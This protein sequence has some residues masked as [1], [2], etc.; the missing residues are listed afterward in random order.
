M[1]PSQLTND[2]GQPIDPVV[3]GW[4]PRPLPPRT[5]MEGRFVRLEPFDLETHARALFDAYTADQTGSTWTYMY[6]GPFKTFDDY[7]DMARTRMTGD[8]PLF[9]TIFDKTSDQPLGVASFMRIAP[10]HGCI[11]VGNISYSPALQKTPGA[12]EAMYLMARRAFDELGYRRYEWKCNAMNAPSRRAALRLGFSF[13]GVFRKHLVVKGRNRDTAWYAM[14]DD[15]WPQI[16]ANFETW[17]SP[18][19]F[20]ADG[21]QIQSLNTLNGEGT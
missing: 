12:T 9:H 8:D 16:K 7:L 15:D 5:P 4:I 6:V 2:M 19:N 10:D 18:D 20:D 1:N 11:E 3:E 17:L 21:R 13:E 14:T